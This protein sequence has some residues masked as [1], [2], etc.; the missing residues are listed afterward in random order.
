MPLTL[1]CHCGDAVT[2]C[3][4]TNVYFEYIAYYNQAGTVGYGASIW[5]TKHEVGSSEELLFG[6][7]GINPG[8]HSVSLPLGTTDDAAWSTLR[9]YFNVDSSL[10]QP[11][12]GLPAQWTI[13]FW[14]RLHYECIDLATGR[15]VK[16]RDKY[17][18]PLTSIGSL[19][20]SGGCVCFDVIIRTVINSEGVEWIDE[21]G[22][23]NDQAGAITKSFTSS[24]LAAICNGC[25]VTFGPGFSPPVK[26]EIILLDDR[27]LCLCASGGTEPYRYFVK[28]GV[29]PP[30]LE[31]DGSTGCLTGIPTG[32][33]TQGIEFGVMD[34]D[35]NEAYATC[36]VSQ[37]CTGIVSPSNGNKAF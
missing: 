18:A 17:H 11:P 16:V 22:D 15:V 19:G 4:V 7:F 33:G 10:F 36:N 9:V 35:F 13:G 30:G 26:H 28:N 27:L 23:T 8:V 25:T 29:L 2:I 31:L 20:G 6:D 14:V 24:P 5:I 1:E 21:D 12:T 34:Y 32:P 3:Q 37:G